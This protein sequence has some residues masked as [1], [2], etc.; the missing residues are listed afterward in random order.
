MGLEA[1]AAL[2]GWSVGIRRQLDQSDETFIG[3]RMV[4]DTEVLDFLRA[5]FA[6]LE[7]RLDRTDLRLDEL[8]QR[9]GR[10]ERETAGLRTEIAN[11]HGDTRLDRIESC[12][13]RIERRLALPR[14]AA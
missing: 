4:T 1:S 3:S 8:T 14:P 10:L 5:Q 9:V 6:Q 7:G 12:L 11:L 2:V 13:D